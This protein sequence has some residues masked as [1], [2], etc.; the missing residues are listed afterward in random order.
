[1]E[2]KIICI[3]VISM[4]LLMGIT[5]L[6]AVTTK[7]NGAANQS[8]QLQIQVLLQPPIPVFSKIVDAKSPQII[9]I[10][11]GS[12]F[13]VLVTSDG[14]PIE[15]AEVRMIPLGTI[16]N[17]ISAASGVYYTGVDGVVWPF[18]KAPII[19]HDTV[20][21]I[22]ASKRGYVPAEIRIMVLGVPIFPI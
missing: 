11:G 16:T 10:L 14:K 6:S 3:G 18:I 17:G 7:P 22:T 20:F 9:K 4:L 8:K 13:W 21:K 2:R 15:K 1:M 19:N 12:K 5:S